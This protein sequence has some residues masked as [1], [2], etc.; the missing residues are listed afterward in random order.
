M[1]SCGWMIVMVCMVLSLPEGATAQESQREADLSPGTPDSLQRMNTASILFD[2]NLNTF[3]WIARLAV[4][5]TIAGT[6]IA[7]GSQYLA[8]IIQQEGMPPGTAGFSESSQ[9]QINLL[10]GRRLST[11][12]EALARWSSL[13]YSDNKGIGLS[14]ASSH[15]VL[16]G[17]DLMPLPLLTVSPLAGYRWDR[18]GDIRDRGP[19]LD[20][21]ADV[22]GL[23]IDGY[24]IGGSARLRKDFMDPRTL[25][26]YLGGIGIEK[27]FGPLSRDSLALGFLRTRRE[28]YTL[29][30]SAIESRT[31]R[32]F[33]FANV[34]DYELNRNMR[35][36]VFVQIGSRVLDKD[37]RR[38][39]G[40]QPVTIFGTE[41][42]EFRLDTQ[43]KTEYRSNDGGTGGTVRFAYAERS[44]SH[45]AKKPDHYPPNLDVLFEERDRQEQTKD[46][47]TRHV[48]L[49]GT[50]SLPF[51]PS[52][53]FSIAGSG[54]ILRY[55][56]PS[57]QNLEDRDELLVAI[58]MGTTH[59]VSR[60]LDLAL[61]LDGTLSH[62]V[63]L[64]KERSANNSVNRVLRLY[65]RT[66]F[67]PASW[68]TTMN[69]FEVLAN[70]T[71][72][73]FEQ[74]ATQVR[75]FSYRQFAL[76]DS[77]RLEC[78]DRIG[79]DFF[80][81]LKLYERGQ[82]KWEEFSER[83][84]NAFVD[85]TLACQ[86]RFTPAMGTMLAVGVRYFS[87]ARYLFLNGVRQ[88]DSFSS[89]V[90]PTCA[91]AWEIGLHSR[92]D[93][94]GWYEHRRYAD[95]TVRSLASMTMQLILH[96]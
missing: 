59:R 9:Q 81:Y 93:F 45:R 92:M 56:T 51:S 31:D 85:Q 16:A 60:Y 12:T 44:E 96:F 35:A 89:S 34:L 5:T 55:D 25:E 15:S 6:R 79:L 13:V 2:Q 58:T 82:L 53:R 8:N 19:S 78:T 32:F 42:E 64:L 18:Q 39:L 3:N 7:V 37:Q 88:E 22:H 86:I 67:R 46:N 69:A 1:R 84:E 48:A 76:V 40:V 72:Y 23:D 20:M 61:M 27:P 83:T 71:V 87:Q 29:G 47:L 33:S 28:F 95:G 36:G 74:Q 11:T 91:I 10:L 94:R 52:D 70:Y 38:I 73:D 4:D 75:S 54:S 24:R 80:A 43:I 57:E 41:I 50:F 21:E 49:A 30:D 65:P 66:T 62:L 17:L 14:N 63:Y 26:N 90:G 77:T 68:C